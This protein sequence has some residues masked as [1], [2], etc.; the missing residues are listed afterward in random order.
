MKIYCDID[1]TLT[2]EPF[3]KWGKPKQERIDKLKQLI[4]EGHQVI[5]WSGGGTRYARQFAKK[6]GI[7]AT[8]AVGKPDVIIDDNPKIR[9]TKRTTY[10]SPE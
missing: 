10:L 7:R 1:G 3:K 9:P 5:L 2:D 4:Q 8:A 6:Y